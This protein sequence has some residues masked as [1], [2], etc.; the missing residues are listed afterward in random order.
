MNRQKSVV[1]FPADISTI[2]GGR[3]EHGY[4]KK[5]EVT[6]YRQYCLSAMCNYNF[7]KMRRLL[8]HFLTI[9]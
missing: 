8:I 6:F 5:C 2:L 3:E 4:Y 1:L 9:C 7:V